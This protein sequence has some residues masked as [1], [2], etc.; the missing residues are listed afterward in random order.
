MSP[1]IVF[2]VAHIMINTASLGLW[3]EGVWVEEVLSPPPPPPGEDG[4]IFELINQERIDDGLRPLTYSSKISIFAWKYATRMID[5]NFYGHI[6]PQGRGLAERLEEAEITYSIAGEIIAENKSAEDAVSA[7]MESEGH[8][9]QI[10]TSDYTSMGI[11]IAQIHSLDK[12]YVVVFY[13]PIES[14]WEN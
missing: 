10:L 8:K 2:L 13:R 3:G 1:F 5:E 4:V 7:W 6:D 12:F 11:G 14:P 9:E